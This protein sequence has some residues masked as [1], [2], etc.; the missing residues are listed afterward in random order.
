MHFQ[1]QFEHPSHPKHSRRLGPAAR[2]FRLA[3][4]NLRPY[5]PVRYGFDVAGLL[6][7]LRRN[8]DAIE[9]SK[10]TRN[11]WSPEAAPALSLSE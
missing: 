6:S 7:L 5:G 4:K 11:P 2:L 10:F 8:A 9:G 1:K 3:E